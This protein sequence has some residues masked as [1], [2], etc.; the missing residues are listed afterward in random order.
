MKTFGLARSAIAVAVLG[1]LVASASAQTTI[2]VGV[3][4]LDLDN[5]NIQVDTP[6]DGTVDQSRINIDITA[7]ATLSPGMYEGISWTYQAGQTGSVIPF[8]A[9]QS[10]TGGYDIFSYGSEVTIGDGDLDAT[11]TVGYGGSAFSLGADTTVYAGILN[12]PGEGQ[13]NPVYT[14]LASGDTVDHDNNNGGAV[15]TALDSGTVSSLTHSNL[16]RSY[17]FSIDVDAVP[18]PSAGL[19]A[20]GLAGLALVK[21]RRR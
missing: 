8:L 14:N 17:A 21:L 13:Q 9:T 10:D 16:A 4:I 1:L 2:G 12:P 6:S 18:E 20:L 11:T 5:P 3:G 19:L 15:G 7:P